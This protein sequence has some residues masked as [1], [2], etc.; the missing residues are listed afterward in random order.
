MSLVGDGG[1]VNRVVSVYVGSGDSFP[2][3]RQLMVSV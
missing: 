1:Y 3:R 2:F